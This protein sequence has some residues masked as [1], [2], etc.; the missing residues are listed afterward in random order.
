MKH[1]EE[2]IS[3][4]LPGFTLFQF[5][6]VCHYELIKY[7][8]IAQNTRIGGPK[9]GCENGF[10]SFIVL[11]HLLDASVFLYESIKLCSLINP[12]ESRSFTE[13]SNYPDLKVVRNNIHTYSRQ[14]GFEK[15]INEIIQQKLI[16]YKLDKPDILNLVRNDISL[17]FQIKAKTRRLIGSDYYISHCFFESGNKKWLG[18]DYL[19]YSEFLSSSISGLASAV[20]STLYKLLDLRQAEQIYSVELFDFKSSDLYR[21]SAVGKSTTFRLILI[22]YQISYILI[23]TQ[24]LFDFKFLS[25]DDLW[26]CF[27][28]KLIAIK[29]D[30]SFDNLESLLNYAIEEEQK[31]LLWCCKSRN[32][33]LGNLPARHFARKLRNTIHYQNISFNSEIVEDNSTRSSVKAIYLSNA[34]VS[35]MSKYKEYGASLIDELK[36]LQELIREIIGLDKNYAH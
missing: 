5:E 1:S 6:A 31:K 16:E 30:E 29:Y 25:N 15:K 36:N 19:E 33:L 17:V 12:D 22:L 13:F 10:N 27:F 21:C 7:I 3:N 24:E 20:D 14:G 35:S 18:K 32:L 28:I 26:L 23:L 2:H 11:G 34:G 8:L 4:L 9:Y